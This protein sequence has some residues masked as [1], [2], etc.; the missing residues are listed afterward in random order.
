MTDIGR[1]DINLVRIG[2]IGC[3]IAATKLLWPAFQQMPE[4][5]QISLVC[6]HTEEKARHFADVVSQFY[7]RSVPY[8]LDYNDVLA[9]DDVDAVAILLPIHLHPEVCL[10]AA[11]AGKHIFVEKP[12]AGDLSGA[13][14]IRALDSAHPELVMMVAENCRYRKIIGELRSVI[15]S[16]EIG[17]PYYIEYRDWQRVDSLT[18]VY[19]RTAWR[20]NHKHIGGFLTDSGV[21]HV[22]ELREVFG[23]M[24]V[25]TSRV[26]SVNDKIGKMDTMMFAFQSDG[27]P[28]IAPVFGV[29]SLAYSAQCIDDHRMWVL[30][31][32]GTAVLEGN[33]LRIYAGEKCK[34]PSREVS[35][36]DDGGYF[37]E[38]TDFHSA[39]LT[40]RKPCSDLQEGFNDLQ[41][42]IDAVNSGRVVTS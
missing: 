9:S 40:G 18:N 8:T 39:I 38:L 2:I 27:L 11:K 41:V 21:H 30:S 3:G 16:G 28:G 36:P 26:V 32:K 10:A 6:N 35:A 7:K 19:A 1:S 31:S 33:S 24:H 20:Q 22:A 13:E 5:F 25:I 4:R 14:K 29:M 17:T 12:L 37:E 34:H 42:I 23:E 15:R